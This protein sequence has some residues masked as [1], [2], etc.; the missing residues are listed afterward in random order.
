MPIHDYVCSNCGHTMEV[1]HSVHGHG[2]STCPKCGGDMKRAFSAPAVHFK[3]SGWARNDRSSSGR[4]GRAAS[5]DAAVGSG[6]V[7]GTSASDTDATSGTASGSTSGA[8]SSGG[9]TGAASGAESATGT[10]A[11]AKDP[12]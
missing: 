7:G 10:V 11:A 9:G 12:D 3:G 2:P 8:E 5:K 4:S 1:M 6:E